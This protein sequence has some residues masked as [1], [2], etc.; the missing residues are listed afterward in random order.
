MKS[1][2]PVDGVRTDNGQVSH[3]DS[4]LSLFF[5]QRHSPH[6]IDVIRPLGS[7][8]L[9][10]PHTPHSTQRRSTPLKHFSYLQKNVIDSVNDVQMTRQQILKHVNGPTFQRLGQDRVIRVRKRFVTNFPRL[11][12]KKLDQMYTIFLLL[13]PRPTIISHYR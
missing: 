4:L 12:E 8:F 5:N 10:S 9:F 3:V 13:L 11:I 7:D 1:G 6:S 2:H